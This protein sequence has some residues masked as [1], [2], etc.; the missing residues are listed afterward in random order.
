MTLPRHLGV[1][2]DQCPLAKHSNVDTPLSLY[3]HEHEK[4]AR[5]NFNLIEQKFQMMMMTEYKI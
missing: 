3:P 5:P 1:G 4:T 2:P